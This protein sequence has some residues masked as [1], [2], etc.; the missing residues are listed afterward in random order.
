METLT[1]ESSSPVALNNTAKN[2]NQK[3]GAKLKR[4]REKVERKRTYKHKSTPN[5]LVGEVK[6]PKRAAQQIYKTEDERGLSLAMHRRRPH[7]RA[8][9]RSDLRL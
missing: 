5:R 4:K 1:S 3:R 8:H 6:N 2:S 7:L 9:C